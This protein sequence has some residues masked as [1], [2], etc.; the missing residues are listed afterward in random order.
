MIQIALGIYCAG[1]VLA[2]GYRSFVQYART[3]STGWA[4][5]RREAGA[6][7]RVAGVLFVAGL[8]SAITGL[9][10]AANSDGA[11]AEVPTAVA[12]GGLVVEAVGLIVAQDGMGDAWRF[13]VDPDERT[14][15]VT[16]GLFGLVRNP[17]FTAMIAAQ[18][19]AVVVAPNV[20]GVLALAA[21]VVAIHLQVR[22]VEE[23][24]LERTH[25]AYSEYAARV[26]R[27]VPRVGR[28]QAAPAAGR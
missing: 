22:V 21:L 12:V 20:V 28:R 3:G 14:E 24:Y 10:L 25:P 15:L 16:S 26:G 8:I 17:V 18:A 27:F 9:V 2:F 6:V 19:G 13:G 11:V 5:I 1:L 4:G 23:P 7:E